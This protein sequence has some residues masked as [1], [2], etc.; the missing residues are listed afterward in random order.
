VSARLDVPE[1]PAAGAPRARPDP[2]EYLPLVTLH[3]T[4]RCNSRCVSCDCW[5]TGREDLT[6][7]A[8]LRLL[9]EL[10]AL[11]T[12]VVIFTGGEPL[13]NREWRAIADALRAQ[14]IKLWLLTAGLALAKHANA[15]AERFDSV[16]VSLDGTNAGTY[17]AIRGLD[18][19]DHVCVGVRAAVRA[20]VAVSLRVTVQRANYLELPRFVALARELGVR[21][22][23]FLAVD[24]GNAHAFGRG[25]EWAR[26][27]ALT[28]ADL[29]RFDAVLRTMQERFADE[30]AS[31]F[32]AESPDKLRRLY[33][34]FRALLGAESFPPVRCNVSTFSAVIG[35]TGLIS[36]CA[37]IRGPAEAG[38]AG[39]AASLSTPA[40]A[41][42]RGDIAAG[43]RPE[44]ERCVCSLWRD[45]ARLR[46]ARFLLGAR[47]A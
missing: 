36:P 10:A 28:S 17:A 39:L 35:A 21:E 25:S 31:G 23:S 3:L 19:F 9:P 27:L 16:T 42:L 15:V 32:I 40:M 41:R 44:C 11:G 38:S 6:L 12:R 24:V 30:F 5:R 22:V 47:Y 13:L 33:E 29:P 7:A 34:Y 8:T 20:G 45:P 43:Q 14:G 4:E 37:F 2:T 26:D 1:T 46:E 18:A